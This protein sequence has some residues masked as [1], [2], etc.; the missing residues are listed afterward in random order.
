MLLQLIFN[1][2]ISICI[3]YKP[4]LIH[5]N[6]AKYP[7][8]WFKKNK[9]KIFKGL[10]N[11]IIKLL[12]LFTVLYLYFMSL[13]LIT[14]MYINPYIMITSAFMCNFKTLHVLQLYLVVKLIICYFIRYY[15]ITFCISHFFNKLF[16]FILVHFIASIILILLVIYKNTLACY[17]VEVP[18]LYLFDIK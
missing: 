1:L 14:I 7:L 10:G 17:C 6:I 12:C 18:I 9:L 3:H 5:Y 8:E 4:F 15:T 13:N 16:H 11:I 2:D